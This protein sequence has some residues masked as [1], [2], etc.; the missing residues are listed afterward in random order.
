MMEELRRITR[1]VLCCRATVRDKYGLWMGVTEDVGASGCQLITTR[2]L[3]VG[4]VLTVTLTSDLFPEE[5]EAVA[6]VAWV[7]PDRLGVAFLK[8]SQRPGALPPS[9]WLLKALEHGAQ[10]DT[11]TTQRIVPSVRR[12]G[13]AGG[14]TASA[15]NGRIVWTVSRPPEQQ[16]SRRPVRSG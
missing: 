7:S 12:E 5:L 15:R 10:P 2:Q 14:A 11:P 9:A 3:R 13:S 6:K 4:T 16:Q 8:P 1:V